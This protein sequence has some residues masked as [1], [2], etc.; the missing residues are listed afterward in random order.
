MQ[1]WLWLIPATGPIFF[2]LWHQWIYRWA[3]FD[4]TRTTLWGRLKS[5]IGV[6]LPGRQGDRHR[7]NKMRAWIQKYARMEGPNAYI[8]ITGIPPT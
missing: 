2:L 4:G 5:D 8:S 7:Y 1:P 3:I 6:S